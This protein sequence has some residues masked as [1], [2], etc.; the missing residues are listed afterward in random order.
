M[1]TDVLLSDLTDAV[2]AEGAEKWQ[3]CSIR[4][5]VVPLNIAVPGASPFSTFLL[6]RKQNSTFT[7]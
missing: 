6:L 5:V 2:P 7:V 4:M 1:S 3:R